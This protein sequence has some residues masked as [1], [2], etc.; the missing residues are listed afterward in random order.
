MLDKRLFTVPRAAV[1][2]FLALAVFSS[3]VN[4]A[5]VE[6]TIFD[7]LSEGSW[8][9]T[10]VTYDL[11][12]YDPP[13]GCVSP[14][15]SISASFSVGAAA[16]PFN[17]K[18]V[19]LLLDGPAGSASDGFAVNLLSDNGS[20]QPGSVIATLGTLT[21]DFLQ[22]A[23]AVYRFN[24]TPIHLP[25]GRYWVNIVPFGN[26]GAAWSY[27]AG[28]AGLGVAG[29]FWSTVDGTYPNGLD[30]NDPSIDNGAYQMRVVGIHE[31]TTLAL[32][33]LGLLGLRTKRRI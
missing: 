20:N 6:T 22:G 19:E 24:F 2:F 26:S 13:P 16:Q 33:G 11:C 15:P 18:F 31:P 29:E 17:L 1:A 7:N 3:M 23:L 12:Y 8:G 27:E 10:P 28:D 4:A 25:N 5:G 9:A 14:P 21:D 30:P 32:V